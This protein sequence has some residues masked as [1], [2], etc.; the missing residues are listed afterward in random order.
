M[1]Y[2]EMRKMIEQMADKNN[3]DFTKALISFEK[4]I[5]DKETLDKLYTDYMENDSVSLLNDEFDYMIDKLPKNDQLKVNDI[6]QKEQNEL[7]NVVGNIVADIDVVER[8]NKNVEQFKVAN[9]SIVSNDDLGNKF[10]T[11]CSAY[12]ENVDISKDF[13]QVDFVKVFGKLE[14][15]WM[16]MVKNIPMLECYIQSY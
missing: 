13:K 4:S 14:L 7:V 5:D 3:E 2:K 9:F 8:E 12:G 10:Y 15:Q 1:S 6:I 16:I 11:N